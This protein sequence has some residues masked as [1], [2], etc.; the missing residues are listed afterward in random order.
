MRLILLFLLMI[1]SICAFSQTDE[2]EEPVLSPKILALDTTL[3]VANKFNDEIS[4]VAAGYTQAF[5]DRSRPKTI[6]QVYKTDEN[7]T[8]KI[9]YKF[10]TDGGDS[11]DSQGK[12]LVNFQKI[13]GDVTVISK[14]Y[15]YLFNA[16]V[17]PAQISAVSTVG[18]EISYK[19]QMHQLILEPD[20]YSPGYW[21]LIFVR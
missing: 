17:E 4:K 19:G 10:T 15:N 11:E 9:E 16:T 2:D 7:E 20:D 3:S 1:N 21:S 14:I 8:L 18:T 5:T 12:P 13:T 6:V